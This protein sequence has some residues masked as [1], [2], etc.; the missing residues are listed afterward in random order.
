MYTSEVTH[1]TVK[2]ADDLQKAAMVLRQLASHAQ[3]SLAAFVLGYQT[4][5]AE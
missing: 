5:F 2:Q 1:T 4:E 3:Y